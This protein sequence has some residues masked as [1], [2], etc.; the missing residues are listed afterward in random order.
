MLYKQAVKQKEEDGILDRV[1]T[2]CTVKHRIMV[3]H[4]N[5]H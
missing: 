5:F 4:L 1:N 3:L 2:K